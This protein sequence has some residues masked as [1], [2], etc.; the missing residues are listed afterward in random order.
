MMKRHTIFMAAAL[1]FVLAMCGAVSA[2]ETQDIGTDVTN[3]A[4]T[5]LGITNSTSPDDALLITTAGSASYKGGTTE[6]SLQGVV[7]TTSAI[8]QGN[9]NLITL[10]SPNAPLEFTFVKKVSNTAFTAKKYT[11]APYG[12]SYSITESSSVSIS[13][14]MT[15]EQWNIAI[16]QLGPNSFALISIASAWANGAP[17]DLLK[18]AG[19][20]GGVSEGLITAYAMSKSFVQ[21]YP[22]NTD[23]QSYHV[24]I[25]PGGGDDDVPM[26]FMDDVPL[27]WASDSGSN[28]VKFYDFY[29]MNNGNPNEN[30]YIWWDRSVNSGNLVLWKPNAQNRID[31]GAFTAGSLKE[32]Q[33]NY[34]LLGLLFANPGKLI[35]IE[36]AVQINKANLDY[37]WGTVDSTTYTP[38]HGIDKTYIAG[39]TAIIKPSISN[40]LTTEDYNRW[41]AVGQAALEEAKKVFGSITKDDL[42]ITSAGYV[43]VDGQSTLGALDGI[44]PAGGAIL[45]NLLSLKRAT[46][47]PLWFVFVKNPTSNVQLSGLAIPEHLNAVIVKFTGFD[48]SG[49]PL[50]TVSSIKDIS[51]NTLAVYAKNSNPAKDLANTF[52][53]GVQDKPYFQQ[54]FYI[55]SVA[56]LWAINTPY[57][58]MKSAIGGGC[59]GSGLT[60]GYSIASYIMANYPLAFGEQYIGVSILAHCKE[61]ALMDT[62]GLSPAAGTYFTTGVQL[63]KNDLT[64]G[65]FII[66]N[67]ITQTGHAVLLNF[68]STVANDMQ[69]ND[70]KGINSGNVGGLHYSSMFWAIW[71][72][73]QA[74]PGKAQESQLNNAFYVV[75]NIPLTQATFNAL[76][77][78]GQN[79][80]VY[81]NSYVAPVNPPV[82][83]TPG[84]QPGNQGTGTRIVS[85][86]STGIAMASA[87]IAQSAS[88]ITEQTAAPAEIAPGLPLG[89]AN[90]TQT[91]NTSGIPVVPAVSAILLAI[92]LVLVYLG[93]DSITSAIRGSEKFGK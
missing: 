29:A 59:P 5:D 21:N 28:A 73:E 9:G 18:V 91:S 89:D 92:I 25:T 55:I 23:K 77:A 45:E 81:V 68:N 37:L 61:Q 60:Q 85:G 33:Y 58:F 86:I 65:V 53:G 27:K 32:M 63:P 17:K 51:A 66:W 19:Y 47:N 7:D 49:N 50:F 10:N 14:D 75:K 11:A 13:K 31:F 78:S 87:S 88:G 69:N 3:R 41:V 83:P 43:L 40:V 76:V 15:Q 71:W 62:L 46:W 54:D 36:N 24:M 70:L 1:I 30:A 72:I 80:A 34:V 16:Q 22:L 79:P 2:A 44:S 90:P 48:I 67:T 38:G 4:G 35:D 26:F 64:S 52:G 20:S 93:R 12:S 84:P 6:D 56:N 82:D 57:S 74:F 39:L 8:T 42:I